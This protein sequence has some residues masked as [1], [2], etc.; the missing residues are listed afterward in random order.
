[1]SLSDVNVS[2]LNRVLD[3]GGWFKP[4]NRA[5][6]VVDLMPYETR[7]AKLNLEPLPGERFSKETWFQMNF[8]SPGFRL[9]FDDK[10][11]D[12]VICGNTV[13]DLT[14]PAPILAEMMRVGKQGVIECPSRLHEQTI[15]VRDRQSTKCGHPHHHWIVESNSEHLILWSKEDSNLE[16]PKTQV[17]L[18]VYENLVRCGSSPIVRHDWVGS[19]GFS[20]VK[21]L[22]CSARAK[23]FTE[24]LGIAWV[25][26]VKDRC[27]RTARR[28]RSYLRPRSDEDWWA[29]IMEQSRPFTKIPLS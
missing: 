26:K 7:W 13:E 5:T 19:I 24:E 14:D 21:G 9:P 8:L 25:A 11:F 22:T 27:L 28:A 17:P 4:D 23:A 10:Y 29:R 12:Y 16:S 15:G 6:H 1:M 3:V 20:F 18:I 2:S